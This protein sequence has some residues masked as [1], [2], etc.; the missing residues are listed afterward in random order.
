MP[1]RFLL[2]VVALV[3]ALAGFSSSAAGVIVAPR[4]NLDSVRVRLARE[5]SGLTDPIAI[6]WRAGDTRMYIAEQIGRVRIVDHGRIVGTALSLSV[7]HGSE[8]GLL[9][10]TFSRDGKKMYVDFTDPAGDT[11]VEEFTMNG[12]RAQSPRQLLIQNQPFPNHNGGQVTIGTDNLLYIGLGD[13]G[14]GGDP[15]DNAQNLD[16]WLGKILRIDPR[17][18]NGQ[19]YRIPTANPFRGMAGRKPEILMYGLRN[20]WRFSLDRATGDMWIGDV[21]QEQYEEIDYAGH[22][23][24]GINYGWNLREGLHAYQGG[25]QPVGGRNPVLERSHASGDC[26][27]VGGYVYRG[28]VIPSLRGA[29]LYGDFC[30]GEIRG[31]VQTNGAIT[32]RRDLGMNVPQMST[33]AEGPKGELRA[34]SHNGNVYVVVPA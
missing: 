34:V 3:F 28:S 31:A 18:L 33:F 17:P 22:G 23:H 21:G 29:Y 32:Q 19:P 26:A 2:L 24:V 15:Q 4:T 16:T 11:H 8:Q 14:S 25:A 5:V 6:A 30:T 27:I 9:G 20:P 1:R 12:P 7:S 13:G 10:L